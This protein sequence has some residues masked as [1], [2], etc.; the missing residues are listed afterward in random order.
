MQPD[1]RCWGSRSACFGA[2][3]DRTPRFALRNLTAKP[4][5]QHGVQTKINFQKFANQPVSASAV[6]KAVSRPA[7][8]TASLFV[9]AETPRPVQLSLPPH[10]AV[11]GLIKDPSDCRG[12]AAVQGLASVGLLDPFVQPKLVEVLSY[13]LKKRSPEQKRVLSLARECKEMARRLRTTRIG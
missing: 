7:D 3:K 2:P 1:F 6:E 9:A 13:S 12:N 10:T 8:G 4:P 5:P 11:R